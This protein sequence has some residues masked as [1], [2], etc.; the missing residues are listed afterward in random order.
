VPFRGLKSAQKYLNSFVSNLENYE[1]V[2]ESERTLHAQ[3]PSKIKDAASRR[4]IKIKQY[5]REKDLRARIEVSHVAV[6][7][8]PT[9]AP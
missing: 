4:D 1:I 3:D 2:P 6:F 9:Y 8:N 5:Q 7:L